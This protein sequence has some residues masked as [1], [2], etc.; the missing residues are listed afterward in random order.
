[1]FSRQHYQAIADALR[2]SSNAGSS[3]HHKAAIKAATLNIAD[4][5]AADNPRFKRDLF[6]NAAGFPP[7]RD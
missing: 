3:E 7:S 4:V 2:V 1:M 6:L 5:F